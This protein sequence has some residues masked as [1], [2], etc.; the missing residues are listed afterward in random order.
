MRRKLNFFKKLLENLAAHLLLVAAE[1]L[2]L[3]P[4]ALY[5]VHVQLASAALAKV[6]DVIKELLELKVVEH[7]VGN[8]LLARLHR[9]RRLVLG[10]GALR[11]ALALRAPVVLVVILVR[12][13]LVSAALGLGGLGLG[14]G[15][16]GGLR[17]SAG[18][19]GA[20]LLVLFGLLLLLLLLGISLRLLAL[21]AEGSSREALAK[22]LVFHLQFLNFRLVGRP[23]FHDLLE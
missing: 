20:S 15:L 17:R 5:E 7:A 1:L 8:R 13:L 2:E 16:C 6:A 11:G 23:I 14:L 21:G 3:R 10:L 9:L 18:C 19:G 4:E 22:G 12:V